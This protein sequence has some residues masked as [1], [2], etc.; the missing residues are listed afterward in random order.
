MRRSPTVLAGGTV[1]AVAALVLAGCAAEPATTHG[2]TVS[3]PSAAQA[4][5]TDLADR[6]AARARTLSGVTDA[7]VE[8]PSGRPR[9]VVVND[10]TRGAQGTA[11]LVG[12][13]VA[14]AA[15][16]SG[17]SAT[18]DPE[19]P[20]IWVAP[21]TPA[22]ADVR[23]LA[24]T[25][26]GDA[27]TG[28]A[29][30]PLASE[31]MRAAYRLALTPGVVGVRADG[32]GPVEV[33]VARA[34]DLVPVA[35]VARA[36]GMPVERVTVRGGGK[37]LPVADAP[38]HATVDAGARWAD[39]PDASAC[40]PADLDL[41][42]VGQDAGLGHRA[43]VVGAT[44]A[45]DAPCALDGYPEIGFATLTHAKLDV[46]VSHG[47]S[48]MAQDPGAHRVVVPPRGRALAVV[49]WDASSTAPDSTGHVPA[50]TAEV[51]LAVGPGAPTTTR[52][53]TSIAPEPGAV[54]DPPTDL[55][56][57]AGGHGTVTAW[58]PGTSHFG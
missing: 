28:P 53:V 18:T 44:N 23:V 52:P 55:D 40:R 12:T 37:S 45:S 41:T 13:L 46:Q 11:E 22:G 30:V 36:N 27:T 38:G 39:D 16:P 26:T 6:L 47:N 25:P 19:V 42:L 57:L 32:T 49:S 29:G 5:P 4:A 24:W 10:A 50:T 58:A 34:S 33:A 54:S 8:R 17:T 21:T 35:D 43:L 20:E 14:E 56:L 51:R 31:A 3:G 9:V 7:T 48:Y 2:G 1:V 15:D